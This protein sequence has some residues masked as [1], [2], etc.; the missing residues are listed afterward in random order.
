MKPPAQ[1]DPV[2]IEYDPGL[3]EEAVR[4][5]LVAETTGRRFLARV[6]LRLLHRRQL[7]A[8]YRQPH[9]ERRELAFRNHFRRLFHELDLDR[10]L[11]RCMELFPQLART[12]QPV[13]KLGLGKGL[14]QII[15]RSS[16]GSSNEGAE[17]W[18]SREQRGQGIPAYLVITLSPS[19]LRCF[20][21]LRDFLLPRLRRAAQLLESGS[22]LASDNPRNSGRRCPL[23]R[24]PTTDW[25]SADL[26]SNLALAIRIDFPAWSTTA[27]CCCHCAERYELLSPATATPAPTSGY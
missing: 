8:I 13:E 24:F 1:L 5:A 22:G 21:E 17:L 20:E 12:S 3:I 15:A 18:E 4:Q 19:R 14:Q 23:C 25:A 9:G 27:G 11:P 26:L 2:S 10:A 16:A 6:R 7:D